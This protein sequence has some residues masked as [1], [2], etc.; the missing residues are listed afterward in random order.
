MSTTLLR[1][2]S[3]RVSRLTASLTDS[4]AAV[5]VAAACSRSAARLARLASTL[6]CCSPSATW[7]NSQVAANKAPSPVSTV[8]ATIDREIKQE[9]QVQQVGAVAVLAQRIGEGDVGEQQPRG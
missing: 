8:A 7:L 3:M 6:V 1:T 5:T 4:S 2:S 9:Q